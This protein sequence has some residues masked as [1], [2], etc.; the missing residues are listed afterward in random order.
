MLAAFDINDRLI[1]THYAYALVDS[2]VSVLP[3]DLL[4]RSL[5][6]RFTH[7]AQCEPH[8]ARHGRGT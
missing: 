2:K 8:E 6:A 3:R 1:D 4:R 5:I 7:E